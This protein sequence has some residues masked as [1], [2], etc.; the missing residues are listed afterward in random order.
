MTMTAEQRAVLAH[1]VLDPDDW[2]AHAVATFGEERAAQMLQAKVGRW[3]PSHDEALAKP[4]Y[5]T[6]AL[7]TN[8]APAEPTAAMVTRRG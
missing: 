2:L 5:K 1:V 8:A 6:R 7:R 4:G 3:K